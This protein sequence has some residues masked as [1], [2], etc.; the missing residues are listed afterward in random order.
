MRKHN[1]LNL[2][3]EQ[4]VTNVK[5]ED[6]IKAT[7]NIFTTMSTDPVYGNI[8]LELIDNCKPETRAFL[9]YVAK[10]IKPLSYLEVGTRRGWSCGAV[11]SASPKCEIY[12]FDEWH[13]NYGGSP[14]PGP[15]FV[16]EEMLKFGYKKPIN[17]I[18][19]DSHKTLKEFFANNPDKM[20]DLMLIDGDHTVDGAW[21]D[22]T[23]TMS[24]IAINGVMVFDDIVDC[25]GLNRI[26]NELKD[27]Y[28]NF[29][30]LA[31]TGNKPGVAIAI[32]V[33]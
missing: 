6:N 11:V 28:P 4:L 5:S 14:N 12:A 19:G 23:D 32:R 13:E 18:N 15:K 21:Q 25:D 31:Y 3:L 8:A 20:F 22:L 26:W 1:L 16:Q 9:Y 24:H 17:F 29:K 27:V 2:D 30:Y 33:E 7:R 10:E